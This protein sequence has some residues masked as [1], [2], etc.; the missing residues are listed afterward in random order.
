MD[1]KKLI[2][3]L[4]KIEK[5]L[6][7]IEDK[8]F[9]TDK[10]TDKELL[11]KAKREFKNATKISATLIQRNLKLG[12]AKSANLLDKLEQEGFVE[13]LDLREPARKVIKKIKNNAKK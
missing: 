7:K 4:N 9:Y 5:R 10:R 11:N 6:K 1:D 12:Y 2:N 13:K 3:I 8:V